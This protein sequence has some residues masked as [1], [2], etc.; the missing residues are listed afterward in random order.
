[1]LDIGIRRLLSRF[2]NLDAKAF[3]QFYAVQERL[4]R[5]GWTTLDLS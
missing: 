2:L 3:A 5:N 4:N 1:M